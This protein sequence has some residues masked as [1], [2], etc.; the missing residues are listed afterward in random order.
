M[1][2]NDTQRTFW[3]STFDDTYES[4][5][6]KNP[7]H[8]DQMHR[9][10]V[11]GVKRE[12]EFVANREGSRRPAAD[13][14]YA[15]CGGMILN[16]RAYGVLYEAVRKECAIYE[17]TIDKNKKRW[18]ALAISC[19]DCFDEV[20]TV[21]RWHD[22]G[23][24]LSVDKLYLRENMI[25]SAKIFRVDTVGIQWS[26]MVDDTIYQLINLHKLSGLEFQEIFLS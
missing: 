24:W 8:K 25:G 6:Q 23:I 20:Q 15:F 14:S 19:Y 18:L 1:V 7:L 3:R 12:F 4:Y 21:G 2:T 11:L 22:S 16:D 9:L 26:Y 10:A 5:Y 17:I 13:I